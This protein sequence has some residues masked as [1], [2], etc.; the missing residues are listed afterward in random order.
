MY[1]YIAISGIHTFLII[2]NMFP[3]INPTPNA[4]MNTEKI[5][6]NIEYID[7]DYDLDIESENYNVGD[8]LPVV[9]ASSS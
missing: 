3:I 5:Y 6:P 4:I 2:P 7:Y 1:S 9:N 8:I